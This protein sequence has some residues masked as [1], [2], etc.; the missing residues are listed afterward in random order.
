MEGEYPRFKSSYLHEELAEGFQLGP[1]EFD[2]VSPRR[3]QPPRNCHFI[4]MFQGEA[5]QRARFCNRNSN[6]CWALSQLP[7]R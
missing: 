1:D 7:S 5:D 6:A 2:F 3:S 4:E